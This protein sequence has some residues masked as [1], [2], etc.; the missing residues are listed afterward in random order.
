[1]AAR[2]RR[3]A[4]ENAIIALAN[5]TAAPPP[6]QGNSVFDRF[7]RHRPPT[8]E[9]TVDPVVLES[10]LREMEKLFTATN[11]PTHEMV[12]IGSYYLKMEAD[13]WWST[14]R[15]SCLAEGEF[16]WSEFAT[17]LK[18]RFYPYELRWQKQEEFLS[19]SQGSLS[20]QEYTNK[21]TALSRFATA[22]VPTEAER[23]KRYIK[24]MDP[25]VRT[26]VLSSG[27]KTFQGAYEIALS[28]HASILEEEATKSGSSFGSGASFKPKLDSN[29]R[30][31][32]KDFHAGKNCD[33]FA[34]VCY[35][36]KEV[37]HKSFKCPKN[38]NAT[39]P[40][41]ATPAGSSAPFK[42]RIY[43]MTQAEANIHPDVITGTFFVNFVP[44]YVLFDTGATVSFV[45]SI[46]VKR[47]I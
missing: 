41:V 47:L 17:K 33:G 31:C 12:S 22:V 2:R 43:V 15:E 46:F 19:L 30:G 40:P 14:V 3:E 4:V 20:I 28:I 1:M 35:Y 16:G 42:N 36:C 29:C 11:C 8:Y 38:P 23:V 6:N 45:S 13:N 24:K 44:A 7:Y 26:H 9:G 27:A 25:K 10:W 39:T 5:R 18:E 21:F 37:G 34:I 32:G